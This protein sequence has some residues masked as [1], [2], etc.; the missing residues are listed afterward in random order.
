MHT[1]AYAVEPPFSYEPQPS[2]VGRVPGF[3]EMPRPSSASGSEVDVPETV[4]SDLFR[5]MNASTGRQAAYRFKSVLFE[6]LMLA[7]H[8]LPG[9][10]ERQAFKFALFEQAVKAKKFLNQPQGRYLNWED[11]D[12][13][14]AALLPKT[15]SI[16]MGGSEED[17]S[18]G[19]I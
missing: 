11:L 6:Q 13:Q 3:I 1:Y 18:L 10:K 2:L 5:I 4:P 15:G 19:W 14:I 7:D 17:T 9:P 16:P 8:L 12:D